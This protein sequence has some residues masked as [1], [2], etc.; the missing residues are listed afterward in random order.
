M[1]CGWCGKTFAEHV[2]SRSPTSPAPRMPCG[3]LREYY[4]PSK[5]ERAVTVCDQCLRASCW[6][7]QM[8]CERARGA[9]TVRKSI[10]QLQEL[11]LEHQSWWA[12]QC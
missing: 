6:Q 5:D 11:G 1:S 4:L 8:M 10:E 9:G 7:G 12:K 3:G 2:T